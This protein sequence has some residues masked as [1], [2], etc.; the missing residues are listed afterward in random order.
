MRGTGCAVRFFIVVAHQIDRSLDG[1][2]IFV[3][4]SFWCQVI[5]SVGYGVL[6][7]GLGAYGCLVPV[8][9]FFLTGCLLSILM[10]VIVAKCIVG[11][12]GTMHIF[13]H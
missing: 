6:Y 9:S 8:C 11:L 5:D 4:Y 2:I 3:D 13:C 12:G 7:C 1:V 10:V